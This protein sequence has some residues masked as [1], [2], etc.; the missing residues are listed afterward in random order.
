[1][2]IHYLVTAYGNQRHL[3]RL[4]QRLAEGNP[5]GISV[6]WDQSKGHLRPEVAELGANV[7]RPA[8]AI[9]WGDTSYLDALLASMQ[10]LPPAEWIVVLSGQDYPLRPVAAFQRM[11]GAATFAGIL[12][13]H[14]VDPPG[15][16][17]WS[18]DQRRYYFQHRWIPP[19]LWRGAGG[20]RGIGRVVHASACL[21]GVRRHVYFR[22]RPRSLPA[23]LGVRVQRDP[24]VGGRR[25]RKGADYFALRRELVDELL[26]SA[27]REP[28]LL[29]HFR[30]S[31]IP[32][33]G[34]FATVL[35]HHGDQ[36]LDEVLHFTR[37][38]GQ[39]S[40]RVLR[41]D[42]LDA[43]RQSGKFFARKFTDDSGPVL[44]LI[45]EHVLGDQRRRDASE[46]LEIS[47]AERQGRHFGPGQWPPGHHW[48]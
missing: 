32:S 27:R 30:R 47:E 24:F 44:D 34:W 9:E 40:P 17:P 43:A 15:R 48:P 26:D 46:E 6:Q 37:F 20:A 10:A 39:S 35:G 36:L 18:E 2:S 12:H 41:S 22:P 29:R 7:I 8:R 16:R 28:D 11:L 3:L 23:A 4:L 19:L 38:E 13:S 33:E 1:V 14:P 42:D 45:D 31:A 25:C 5:A 21:P